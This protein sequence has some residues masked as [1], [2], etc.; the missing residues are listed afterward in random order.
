M[1]RLFH[2]AFVG[3]LSLALVSCAQRPGG[4]SPFGSTG[5][6]QNGSACSNIKTW[7]GGAV[8]AAGGGLLGSQFGGGS[9]KL[10]TTGAGVLLGALAGAEAGKSLDEADC[11]SI[12]HSQQ[13]A[14]E[15][16]TDGASVPWN[17][18]NSGHGGTVTPVR[19]FQEPNGTYCREY[20]TMITVDG[21]AQRGHGTACR[22]PDGSWQVQS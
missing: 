6:A 18:P 22:M 1:K 8:G 2:V 14:L 19:T 4:Y 15:H 11:L 5:V 12:Q 16:A 20:Q 7:V 21:Q 9:G 17:N 13:A 10:V 3:V